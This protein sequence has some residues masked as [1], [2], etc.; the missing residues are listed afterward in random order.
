[1]NKSLA[2]QALSII[3]AC[4]IFAATSQSMHNNMNSSQDM[5]MDSYNLAQTK[6]ITPNAS[7]VVKGGLDLFI[8]AD[9]IYWTA[10]QD[11]LSYALTSNIPLTA[12]ATENYQTYA[13]GKSL[14]VNNK[15]SP[16]FKVGAGLI[17]DHDGWDLY[18]QYTWFRTHPSSSTNSGYVVGTPG[19]D[20]ILGFTSHAPF[21]DDGDS[22][23]TAYSTWKLSFNEFDLELG[24]NY[25]ISQKLTLR[26]HI[27]FKGGWQNQKFNNYWTLA[28]PTEIAFQWNSA[29]YNIY[30]KNNFWN[31]GLRTGLDTS[32]MFTKNWSLFGDFAISTLWSKFTHKRKDVATTAGS[33]VTT[34]NLT[35]FQ[36]LN[37]VDYTK[38]LTPV[39]ELALGLRFDWW[40]S[41]DDYRF[42][43]QAGWEN[44]VWFNTNKYKAIAD[45]GALYQE[46]SGNLSLQGLTIEA[47]FDF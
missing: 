4:S 42:R 28:Q 46:R 36:T 29:N 12:A 37:N 10:R 22:F 30:Q 39:I 20:N 8:D 47:R 6:M 31:I 40:F 7:P 38:Q 14:Y 17:L 45:R 26:P 32:W 19:L 43:L 33:S 27:G 3:S 18:F 5:S 2:M 9:F 16:G 24:R 25:Y 35:D 15:Y 41:D 23:R 13:S 11:G 34:E 21:D 1:M 44:Q